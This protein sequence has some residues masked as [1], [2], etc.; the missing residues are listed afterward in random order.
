MAGVAAVVV[1]AGRGVR[2]GGDV[3]KQFRPVG[4]TPML[5][6][7]LVMLVEHPD[8][9]AVQ[10]VIHPDDAEHFRCTAAGLEVLPPVFGGAS[11]QASVR[12]GLE[13]LAG[14]EPEIVLI[15]DAARPFASAALVSRAIEAAA[16]FGAAIP[17]LPVSDTVK[18]VD[19]NARVT[20]TLDRAALRVAQTPQAFGFAALLK[21]HRRAA[22]EG[23]N[24]F[25]D[26]A[27]LAEWAGLAVSAFP[28]ERGNIKFTDPD[29]F[30][31]A[32]AA[33]FATLGDVRTGTGIDVHSF[34]P[35]DH[36]TLGGVRIAHDRALTGHSDADVALHALVDAILGAL[37]DGDIGVHFPP[38]DPQWRGASSDK[39]MD[40]AIG[41]LKA[42][43]GRIAHIDINLVCEGPR[44]GPHRDAMRAR[45][46]QLAGID[47]SRVAVKAT[48]SE[49]LGFIGRGEGI[50]AYATATVRLPW[51]SNA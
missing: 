42:R 18:T 33:Q 8:V 21:A 26:D 27:A 15:H 37:A 9:G 17:T 50:V 13:A 32:E 2:A 10:P 20:G 22:A 44:I 12:A 45:I 1:A 51:D 35:G 4:G 23:R 29:D 46:A 47:I 38:S 40:F 30:M 28:G 31:R 11:R 49:K 24:D 48:T 39:F 25:T 16:K 3:P 41:R 19:A 7:S 5:R 14:H 6:H 36:V 43:G 34:A